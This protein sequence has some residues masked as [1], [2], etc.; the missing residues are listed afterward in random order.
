M[1][2]LVKTSLT[3]VYRRNDGTSEF[4]KLEPG[5]VFTIR[6]PERSGLVNVIH[7]GRIVAVFMRDVQERAARINGASN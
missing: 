5:T 6:G 3:A 7:Q 2:Y 4:V 1:K